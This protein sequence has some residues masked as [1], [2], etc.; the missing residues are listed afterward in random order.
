MPQMLQTPDP[1]AIEGKPVY[2]T[3][4][5]RLQEAVDAQPQDQESTEFNAGDVRDCCLACDP[6]NK[7]AAELRDKVKGLSPGASVSLPIASV[8]K[9]IAA[10]ASPAPEPETK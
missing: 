2:G 6:K 1:L 8:K 10:V 3:A 9:L 5:Y 7:V 4:L